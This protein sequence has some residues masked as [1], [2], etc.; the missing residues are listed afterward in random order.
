MY[1]YKNKYIYEYLSIVKNY[2]LNQFIK[3]RKQK[4]TNF[5][6]ENNIIR[7][8]IKS[9]YSSLENKKNEI[10]YKNSIFNSPRE[11]RKIFILLIKKE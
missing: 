5:L 2:V 7:K 4:Q 10:N 9:S 6:K 11:F 1:L 3:E 8:K